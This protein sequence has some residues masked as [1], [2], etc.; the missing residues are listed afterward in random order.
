[1]SM[2]VG[3]GISAVGSYLSAREQREVDERRMA[4]EAE[5]RQRSDTLNAIQNT[6][7][8]QDV[9]FQNI[10]GAATQSLFRK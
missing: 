2:A 3:G 7:R 10:M 5:M 6:G 1:M 4:L 9:A 8:E